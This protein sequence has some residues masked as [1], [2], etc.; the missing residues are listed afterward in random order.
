MSEQCDGL[1]KVAE[2]VANEFDFALNN[3]DWG[4]RYGLLRDLQNRLRVA[5]DKVK[6]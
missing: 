4:V 5:L 6:E 3:F 2:E 1:V